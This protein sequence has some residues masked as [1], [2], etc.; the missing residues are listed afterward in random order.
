MSESDVCRRQIL[1]YKDGPRTKRIKI[2]L[3]SVDPQHRYSNEA[4]RADYDVSDV[5]EL[6][7]S[8]GFHSLY[9][10]VSNTLFTMPEHTNEREFSDS[11][12]CV[13]L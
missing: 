4:E 5:F 8:F 9:K 6:K 10:K 2:F 12:R 13:L 3:I 7:K 1:P 11:T